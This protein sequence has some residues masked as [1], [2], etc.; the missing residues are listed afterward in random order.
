MKAIDESTHRQ[1]CGHQFLIFPGST[2]VKYSKWN[3]TGWHF[4]FLFYF[5]FFFFFFIFFFSLRAIDYDGQQIHDYEALFT[6]L[7]ANS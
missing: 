5:F 7:K 2:G 3:G 6:F 1:T 4:F